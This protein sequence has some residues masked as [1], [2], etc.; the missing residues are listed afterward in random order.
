MTREAP[1]KPWIRLLYSPGCPSRGPTLELLRK[2]LREEGVPGDVELVEVA[3]VETAARENFHGSPSIQ[4]G[5]KDIVPGA[6]R[7]PAG[8]G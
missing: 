7:A 3:D 6:D 2:V 5:G 8:M 4:V 1:V